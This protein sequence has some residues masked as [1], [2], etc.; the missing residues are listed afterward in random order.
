MKSA[1]FYSPTKFV[2][3]KLAVVGRFFLFVCHRLKCDYG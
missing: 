2:R 1:Y 3:E